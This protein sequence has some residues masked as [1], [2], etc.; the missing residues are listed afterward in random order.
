M[1]I[2]STTYNQA[3]SIVFTKTTDSGSD[4][5]GISGNTFFRNFSDNLP[6][7]KNSN[8]DVYHIF[9]GSSTADITTTGD[10]YATTFYGDGSQLSGIS[11]DNFYS[12]GFTYDDANTFT[13]SSTGYSALTATFNTVSGLTVNGT[14]SAT[15]INGSGSGLTN[16]PI[17]GVNSLQNE[18][19]NKFDKSGGTVNGSVIITGDVTIL[20]T[21]TT[22]NTETLTV[23]DNIVTLNSTVTGNTLPY[24]GNSGIEVLRGSATTTTLLWDEQNSYWVAGISGNTKQIILSGDSLSLLNSGHTHPISEVI[25]LQNELNNKFDTTGGTIN[26]SITATTVSA[27]TFYGDGSNLTGISTA[28][29]YS[30]GF[31]YNDANTF[32]ISNT[33]YSALTATFNTVTGL[34]VNGNLSVTGNT[35]VKALSGTSAVFSGSGQNILTVVGSGSTSP[36]FKISGS[37]SE[38]FS[39]SDITTGL[40]FTVNNNIGLPIFQ[41]WD[42]FRVVMGSNASPGLTVSGSTVFVGPTA[43]TTSKLYISTG[44][45]QYNY[46]TLGAGRV[47]TSDGNGVASWEVAGGFTGGTV[48]GPVIFTGGL[49][50]NTISATTYLNLPVTADTTVTAFTYNNNVFTLERN[51]NL[52]AL[53]QTVNTMTGLTVNG[54]LS[55]TGD[56]NVKGLSG[57]S[58]TLSGS[59]QNILTIIGSGSTSPLF[60]ISGASGELFSVTDSLTGSLL[61][62]NNIIG[63]PILQVWE[64]FR[65]VMGSNTNPALT[66]SGSTVFVGPTGTTSSLLHISTGTLQYKYGS[67]ASGKVLT[68]DSNGVATWETP[69]GFTGGTVTGPVIFTGGLSANTISA[70]TYQNLPV[71]ADTFTTGFTYS[72]NTFTLSR[73]GG[74]SALTQTVNTMTGLTVN[75]TL[76]ATTVYSNGIG[77]KTTTPTFDLEV[78]GTFG[79]TSKSFVIKHPTQEGKKLVYGAIEGPEFG[80]YVRGKVDGNVIELPEEWV[81]LVDEATITVQL[82]GDGNFKLLYVKEIK[83]NKV[84]ISNMIPFIKPTG[85]YTVY[86]ERKDIDKL[87]TVI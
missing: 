1:S 24:P 66:V 41:T 48:T 36:L 29:Y 80:V 45:L 81:G 57:T 70:T 10:V 77:I 71:T 14:L 54:N 39:V 50:A 52:S 60:K 53:T 43:T 44:P 86:G 2:S 18:L 9:S 62:V 13:I 20:G 34:T 37:T 67:Y 33:G 75:G 55:V 6:Y 56:T 7:Y 65:L 78:N 21:A 83:N 42:D 64:D 68:S 27:T 84:Y 85:Y 79:A 47:L 32:T 38:L 16:I 35:N 12:T 23:K 11:T 26:G 30:T 25:N 40:I 49:S 31:T 76:S 61:T 17:S 82:T 15:T 28:N 8:G 19:D 63:L 69:T 87:K 73:N 51:G 4:F 3:L 58:A 59:A 5:S 74:L 22:I 46:G 72:D